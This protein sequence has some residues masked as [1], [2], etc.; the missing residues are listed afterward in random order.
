MGV[1]D[2]ALGEG[3][4]GGHFEQPTAV[5]DTDPVADMHDDREVVADHQHGQPVIATQAGQQV[6]NLGLDRNVERRGGLVEQQD[7]WA[8]E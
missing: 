4:S 7:A 3:G 8:R 1:G 6:E 5:H 2:A